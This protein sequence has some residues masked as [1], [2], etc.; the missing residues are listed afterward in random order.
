MYH[1]DCEA[2]QNSIDNT[3]QAARQSILSLL[4]SGE[5]LVEV[6]LLNFRTI[7]RGVYAEFRWEIILQLSLWCAAHERRVGSPL[8]NQGFGTQVNDE[9]GMAKQH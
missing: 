7:L 6:E 4:L 8:L 3:L 1:N 5:V 2:I 9:D